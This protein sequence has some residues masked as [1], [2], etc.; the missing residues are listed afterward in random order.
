MLFGSQWNE[1]IHHKAHVEGV[2]QGIIM[3]HRL[4]KWPMEWQYGKKKVLID[5]WSLDSEAKWD[6]IKLHDSENVTRIICR[7]IDKFVSEFLIQA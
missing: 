4:A 2:N 7:T 3:R 5:S 6:R 1:E